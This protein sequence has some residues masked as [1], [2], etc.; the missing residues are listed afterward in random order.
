M[1]PIKEAMIR[2]EDTGEIN[3]DLDWF[4]ERPGVEQRDEL[5]AELKAALGYMQ[6]AQIDLSTGAPKKTAIQTLSG[7][8]Q[9][10]RTAIVK[11]DANPIIVYADLVNAL[12]AVAEW[13][14]ALPPT[15]RQD[16]EG[17]GAVPG[18]IAN[19]SAA[20]ARSKAQGVES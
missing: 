6:N 4:R 12:E 16:I 9:R 10:V 3:P 2:E 13:W 18:C 5:I 11:A 8:I 20:L 17:S 7:G 19:V 1:D 14:N 15:L